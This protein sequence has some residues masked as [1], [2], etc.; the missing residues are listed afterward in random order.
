MSMGSRCVVVVLPVAFLA[1]CGD[2]GPGAA[3]VSVA[4]SA[5]VRV[6]VNE[7]PPPG[8]EGA[9]R[10]RLADEPFLQIGVGA[11]GDPELQFARIS[12]VHRLAGGRIAVVDPWTP[13]LFF[14]ESDGEMVARWDRVGEGPGELQRASGTGGMRGSF[15]CGDG[16]LYVVQQREIMAFDAEGVHLRTFA[17]MPRAEVRGC[18]GERIVGVRQSTPWRDEPGIHVDSVYLAMYDLDGE[19]L[20]VVDSLPFQERNYSTIPSGRTGYAPLVFGRSLA[21]G[22]GVGRIATGFGDGI[23]VELRDLDGV[24]GGIVRVRGRDRDISSEEIERFRDFVFNPWGGN[25]EERARLEGLLAE[26]SEREMP[27]LAEILV[28]PG[29]GL[30]IRLYDHLDALAFWDRSFLVPH[31][32]PEPERDRARHWVLLDAE[33]VWRGE[34]EV[35]PDF[36]IHQVG[37]DWVLGVWRDALDVEYV[38]MIR[39]E[40]AG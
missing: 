31:V 33:G 16:T 24:L 37:E 6:V 19:E 29:G 8:G 34:L 14:F 30:W 28:A 15:T 22:M 7:A 40:G 9:E 39:L 2:A 32:F 3:G 18:S 23:E 35:P 5:G 21:I 10:L 27:G 38:R 12:G 13:A 20:A 25:D 26:A 36:E 4:D 17:L 11:E 1:G